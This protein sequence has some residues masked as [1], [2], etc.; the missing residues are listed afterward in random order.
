MHADRAEG[1]GGPA[2][3]VEVPEP[4]DKAAEDVAELAGQ[5][6]P[7]SGARLAG[8]S[9]APASKGPSRSLASLVP[10]RPATT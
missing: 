1:V 3:L 8:A 6:G 5:A 7:R 4:G 2:P 9:P 10:S